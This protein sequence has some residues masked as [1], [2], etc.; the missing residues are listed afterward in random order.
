MRQA[1]TKTTRAPTDDFSEMSQV[2]QPANPAGLQA[3]PV[4]LASGWHLLPFM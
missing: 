1:E 4:V 2:P 3:D